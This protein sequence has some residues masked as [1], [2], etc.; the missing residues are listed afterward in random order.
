M[1]TM[2]LTSF[3]VQLFL[4]LSL[5]I[6][7]CGYHLLRRRR[8]HAAHLRAKKTDLSPFPPTAP[9]PVWHDAVV[10]S[11]KRNQSPSPSV[12]EVEITSAPEE[13]SSAPT[14]T[15][16]SQRSLDIASMADT[17]VTLD[18]RTEFTYYTNTNGK[19]G[20]LNDRCASSGGNLVIIPRSINYGARAVINWCPTCAKVMGNRRLLSAIIGGAP[21]KA[22]PT[23]RRK[24]S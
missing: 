8:S 14:G 23:Q 18:D 13:A 1:V 3:M 7:Y 15:I 10:A 11:S 6:F 12:P 9:Y 19:C 16:A 5:I 17:S 2:G 4:I 24:K 22:P 21:A 20:H